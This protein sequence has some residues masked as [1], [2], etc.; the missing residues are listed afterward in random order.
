M[1]TIACT[2]ISVL[3]LLSA[4]A[5]T[6]KIDAGPASKS[7]AVKSKSDAGASKPAPAK[8]A[9]PGKTTTPPAGS[10]SCAGKADQNSCIECCEQ[11]AGGDLR[12]QLL[13][14]V[15]SCACEPD[16]PCADECGSSLCNLPSGLPSTACA[17][18][19]QAKDEEQRC[20]AA[21]TEAC[22][23]KTGCEATVACVTTSGCDSQP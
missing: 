2:L 20:A 4:V 11:Q 5:C 3:S 15:A 13:D 14:E 7:D 23:G 6:A 10:A 16:A 17:A 12:G 21:P 18:C 22:K 19:L 8:T 9:E 1:K